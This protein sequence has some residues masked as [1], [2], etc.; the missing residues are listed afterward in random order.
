MFCYMLHNAIVKQNPAL[1][2]TKQFCYFTLGFIHKRS[3][4]S[5]GI[6]AKFCALHARARSYKVE[7]VADV[8]QI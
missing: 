7:V 5:S 4:C 2:S 3:F 1:M 6:K 8:K